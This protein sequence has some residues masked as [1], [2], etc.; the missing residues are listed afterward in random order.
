MVNGML[1]ECQRELYELT[2]G[3]NELSLAA[4][5]GHVMRVRNLCDGW[6]RQWLHFLQKTTDEYMNLRQIVK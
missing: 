3:Y 6:S 2:S 1:R 5:Q 4:S